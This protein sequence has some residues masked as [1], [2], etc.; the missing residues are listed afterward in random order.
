M[1]EWVKKENPLNITKRALVT[2][3][4]YTIVGPQHRRALHRNIE[5]FSVSNLF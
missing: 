1:I 2:N 4:I 3:L 5:T